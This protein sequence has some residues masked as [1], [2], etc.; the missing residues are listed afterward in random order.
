ML[1]VW[2]LFPFTVKWNS[3]MTLLF[4]GTYLIWER[5]SFVHRWTFSFWNRSVLTH[6]LQTDCCFIRTRAYH[7]VVWVP[8]LRYWSDY[9]SDSR[10]ML[11]WHSRESAEH[12]EMIYTRESNPSHTN[13]DQFVFPQTV[14]TWFFLFIISQICLGESRHLFTGNRNS[15]SL[16]WLISQIPQRRM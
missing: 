11:Q 16:L 13:T 1:Q 5:F 8:D 10:V 6:K 12:F 2:G 9:S 7:T 3:R 14:Q 15:K 4:L